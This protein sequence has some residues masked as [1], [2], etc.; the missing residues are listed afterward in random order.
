MIRS[1]MDTRMDARVIRAVERS[2]ARKK[3]GPAQLGPFFE[4]T[5]KLFPVGADYRCAR[6]RFV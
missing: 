4:A 6:G 5:T 3:R 2:S 1:L